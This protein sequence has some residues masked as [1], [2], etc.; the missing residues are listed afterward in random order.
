MNSQPNI[1]GIPARLGLGTAGLG[2]SSER[3]DQEVAAV[4]F[5][6]DTGYRVI[7]TAEW[8][9]AGG[10]EKV[11]GTA[12]KAFG[13]DRRSEVF[14]MSKVFPENATFE[15]T[16]RACEASVERL[17]SG[18]IDLYLLHWRGPHDFK[19]TLQAFNTLRKRKL[20]RHFGV[21]NFDVDD[22]IEWRKAEKRMGLTNGA[23][24]N[25]ISYR[26]NRRGIEYGQLEWHR[27]HG[28]Q[29]SAMAL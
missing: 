21:S 19:D 15:G 23:T 1:L 14:L 12:L 4:K 27:V 24:A 28:F 6:L 18:Y 11:I 25:E 29:P 16:I 22:L 7:D 9:G 20:I 3:R 10:A 13:K 2:E 5:A 17:G 8:Y 26:L